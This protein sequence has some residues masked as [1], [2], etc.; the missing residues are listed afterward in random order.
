MS[1]TFDIAVI[2]AGMAGASIAAELAVRAKVLVLEMEDQPGHH[3][4]GRSAAAFIESYGNA[5]IRK[6]NRAS[7]A[8][9][10]NPPD[11]IADRS[12]LKPRGILYLAR[13]GEEQRLGDLLQDSGEIE[14][15]TPA[16]AAA[17]VPVLNPEAI[18]EAALEASAME[19][20]VSALHSGYL[21]AFKR[22]GG[23]LACQSK[24]ETLERRGRTWR[25]TTGADSYAASIV[26]NAAGAWADE[27]AEAAGLTPVGLTPMRRSAAIVAAPE[28]VEVGHWPIV[29]DVGDAYYFLPMGGK[30]M[31][32]PADEVPVRAHDA[33]ADDL[34]LAAGIDRFEQA[35]TFEVRRVE[36]TWAGLRTFAPD[37]SPVVGLDPDAADFFWFAGQGGTGIQTAPA[38][39]RL[40]AA[41]VLGTG[42]PADLTAGGFAAAEVDPARLRPRAVP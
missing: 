36:R 6:L 31:I 42:V 41:L 21:R 16:D 26:V 23:R 34:E 10:R 30:L 14:K 8:F 18:A 19:I 4:T 38:M 2:G 1:E 29:Y 12:L 3:A 13:P 9:L 33:F 37:R 17:R 22:R 35:V 27:I 15:I 28:G 24:V 40:G 25:V 7:Q 5:T 39:A 11:E 20:D 32:S